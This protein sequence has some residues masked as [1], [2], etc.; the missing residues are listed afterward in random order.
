MRLSI[1]RDIYYMC[2]FFDIIFLIYFFSFT[3]I[4]TP[5]EPINPCY[6]S[7]CGPNSQC[8][9][10]NNQAICSCL[11]TFIGSPPGCRP[12][13]NEACTNQKCS[14]PCV[15]VCGKN[16]DCKVINHS[17]ICTCRPKFT[18]DPFTHCFPIPSNYYYLFIVISLYLR[19]LF[20]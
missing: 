8:K 2:F 4:D 18:G 15:A 12:E 17:P 20:F 6:P 7:P 13:S 10:I 11:P 3:Y 9:S 1:F 16:A 19:S 14:D 5:I